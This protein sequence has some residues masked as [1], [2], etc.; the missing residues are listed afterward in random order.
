MAKAIPSRVAVV[1]VLACVLC[2]VSLSQEPSDQRK[3]AT[4]SVHHYVTTKD[5]KWY[6]RQLAPLHRELVE[7]D[8][9]IRAMRQARK[10]GRGTTGAV[11]LNKAP[12]GVNA[13]ADL[14]LLEK[15]RAQVL[16]HISEI[17]D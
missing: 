9:Q 5:P 11:N 1:A 13:D 12:E 3:T 17:E 16:Q 4:D 2:S 8:Q 7:I 6:A 14:L 15:R 10:D